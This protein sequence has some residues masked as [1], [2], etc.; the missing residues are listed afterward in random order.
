MFMPRANVFGPAEIATLNDVCFPA[1][2]GVPEQG[3]LATSLVETGDGWR[4]AGTL[5]CRNKVQTWDGGLAEV[6]RV[7]RYYPTMIGGA[8]LIRVP[9]GALDNCADLWLAPDQLVMV[10]S[11]VVEEVLDAAGALVPARALV[12][13]RDIE[14]QQ[15]QAPTEMI[16]L[17]FATEELVYV[18]TGALVLAAAEQSAPAGAAVGLP[19]LAGV[20]ARAM[21]ELIVSGHRS[22]CD[23]R[24]VA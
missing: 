17:G 2:L 11:P 8:G 10:A 24:R 1:P 5:A 4:A 9:G 15:R 7:D 18:N 12:G 20:R 6:V 14:W 21:L 13:F 19:V 23:L 22:T 3:I 16:R